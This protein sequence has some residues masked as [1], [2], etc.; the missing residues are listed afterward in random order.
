MINIVHAVGNFDGI[1]GDS[2]GKEILKT[3]WYNR[4]GGWGQLLVCKD[5]ALAKRAADIAEK[6][7][8][9]DSY[10]YSKD[11]GSQGRWSGYQSIK[12]YITLHNCSLDEA[13]EKGKGNFDCSSLC[14][15]CYI[16]AGLKHKASGYTGSIADSFAATG[17][18]EIY[19]DEEHVKDDSYA[20]I[21]SLYLAP[22]QH[23]AMAVENSKNVPEKMPGEENRKIKSKG[24]I[25]VRSFP[26]TG[27]TVDIM[28]KGETAEIIGY[29]EATGWYH[30][31]T[32]K[33]NGY[34]TN[35]A[36]YVEVV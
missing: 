16:F 33:T 32:K 20:E 4:T 12:S 2:S 3:K 10:G 25:R 7:A 19:S 5:K 18:F 29:D 23:V 22:R 11:T 36:Q 13:I 28:H 35:K 24:N 15:S 1:D 21:G 9:N 30:V 17:E 8:K 26:V 6:I 34:V 31:K 27:K 14:I